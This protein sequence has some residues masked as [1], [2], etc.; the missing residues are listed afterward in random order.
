VFSSY[1]TI[2]TRLTPS[3]YSANLVLNFSFGNI[4]GT[5][6][7]PRIMMAGR[8]P[9]LLLSLVL[10]GAIA[11][12][13]ANASSE[14]IVH[15][16]D[17]N[18]EGWHSVSGLIKVGTSLYGMTEYGGTHNAG[19]VFMMTQGGVE[20]VL[21]DF[22]YG[23]TDGT[24]PAGGLVY[25]NGVLYG[26]TTQGGTGGCMDGF[27]NVIG[28]GTVF[29]VAI[30][31]G[32]ESVLWSFQGG[33]DGQAPLRGLLENNGVL[34]GTTVAGGSSACVTTYASCGIAFSLTTGGVETVLHAF[35]GHPDGA[36]PAGTLIAV[37][38]NLY[39]TTA[40]G[41]DAQCTDLPRGCGTI[42]RLKPPTPQNPQWVEHTLYRF[43]G[44]SDG[45][46]PVAALV[47]VNGVFYGTTEYGGSA[48]AG[49]AF[50]FAQSVENVLYSFQGG[51]DG[52][53]P[54]TSLTNI[55]GTLYGVTLAGGTY[56]QG[57]CGWSVFHGCGTIYHLI[58]GG[59]Q[60][61]Y[62]FQESGD[63]VTPQAETLL[64]IGGNLYGT[65]IGGGGGFGGVYRFTP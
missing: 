8:R 31:S 62:A 33:S 35:Q 30:P 12:S 64:K 63:V 43:H 41:G 47:H 9:G 28:C 10:L 5:L 15:D 16:F 55:G 24:Y 48:H 40:E 58:P 34:Y 65:T 57:S 25:F 36:N 49:T 26:T 44:G 1:F 38:Q 39:G 29:Q 59:I 3:V 54:I 42:F 6:K 14:A 17:G 22:A 20:T 60:T 23:G 11:A 7:M 45:A 4:V 37:G 50:S 19:T 27:G 61:D 53:F 13:G 21:H 52:T 18:L 46:N 51:S 32:A 2:A 56:L